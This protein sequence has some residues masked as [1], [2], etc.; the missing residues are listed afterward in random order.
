MAQLR[1]RKAR[2]TPFVTRSNARRHDSALHSN[3][4][5]SLPPRAA[6]L[7][8]RAVQGIAAGETHYRVTSRL[9]RAH[10]CKFGLN[11]SSTV[12]QSA[13]RQRLANVEAR[14]CR[15]GAPRKVVRQIERIS[16]NERRTGRRHAGRYGHGRRPYRCSVSKYP[17]T[18]STRGCSNRREA[19]QRH[20]R[21]AWRPFVR[22]DRALP[23]RQPIRQ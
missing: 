23:A 9:E 10:V 14:G 16:G 7:C 22:R 18:G 4:G 11:R 12:L 21:I 13:L 6:T 5:S 2:N 8:R 15:N 17:G 3:S 19:K 20:F 1:W